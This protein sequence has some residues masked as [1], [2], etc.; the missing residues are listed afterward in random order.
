MT[1]EEQVQQLLANYKAKLESTGQEFLTLARRISGEL[2]GM[3][4]Q[5]MDLQAQNKEKVSTP[6]KEEKTP[7]E[8]AE[9]TKKAKENKDRATEWKQ[10]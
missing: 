8:G 1:N 10:D 9:A 3:E 2:G 6:Q 5:I 7:K 4:K